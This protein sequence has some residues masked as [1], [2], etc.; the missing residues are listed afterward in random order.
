MG[1]S[2][3][4]IY[5]NERCL[6]M[7]SDFITIFIIPIFITLTIIPL[8]GELLIS[9]QSFSG[10]SEKICEKLVT[11]DIETY[12]CLLLVVLTA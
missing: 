8:L 1:K 6:H 9:F 3:S 5:P 10:T 7:K 11:S 4:C 2:L 12:F